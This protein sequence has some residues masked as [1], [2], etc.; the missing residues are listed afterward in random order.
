MRKFL[1]IVLLLIC[2]MLIFSNRLV[3]ANQSFSVTFYVDGQIYDQFDEIPAMTYLFEVVSEMNPTATGK[4]FNGWFL[5]ASYTQLISGANNNIEIDSNIAVY[6]YFETNGYTITFDSN[7]GTAVAA[8]TQDYGSSITAPANPTRTGYTFT[9]WSPGLPST[10]PS[11]D[12]T[13]TAQWSINSYYVYLNV[14]GGNYMAPVLYQYNNAVT[15]PSAPTKSGSTFLG[16]YFDPNYL[17]PFQAI[18]MPAGHLTLYARWQDPDVYYTVSFNSNGGSTISPQ[19]VLSGGT[20]THPPTAPIKQGHTFVA[21]YSDEGLTTEYGFTETVTGNLTLYAKYMIN[22]YTITFNT[23]GGTL[24]PSITQNYDTVIT[25]P[26]NPTRTGYTFTGWS[27]VIPARMPASNMTV[28]AQWQIIPVYFSV[29]FNSNGGSAVQSQSVLENSTASQPATP[30]RAGFTFL[31]WFSDV[32]LTTSFSFTTP[33]TENITL[34]AK[35][36]INSYNV[37]F[38]SNGG[39]AVQTQSITYN[40]TASLPTPPTKQGNIFVG[41]YQDV[42]LTVPFNFN[43]PITNHITLYAKWEADS[44]ALVILS[45]DSNGGSLVDP[46]TVVSGSTTQEPQPPIKANYI[47]VGW[48]SDQALT[49]AFNWNAPITANTTLYARW[50]ADTSVIWTVSFNSN[51]GSPVANRSVENGSSVNPPQAP[52][53]V[54]FMFDGWFTTIALS[55]PYTFSNPVTENITL[56]AKW[57]PISSGGGDPISEDPQTSEGSAGIYILL[58]VGVVII[59]SGLF[60]KK[61]RY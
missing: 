56:H 12:T 13:Q 44:A 61:R 28:T 59:L 55:T 50:T 20:A 53:R 6:G 34:Y 60:S 3:Y 18:N 24:V 25:Q 2:N 19:N 51:G 45:F 54:G 40:L 29:S 16:W 8:I 47:F 9:G 31:G 41:W 11:S 48:F 33:I 21:W 1:L 32:G 37:S 23:N 35:W 46:I 10:M 22:Q 49:Q 14:E 42:N 26:E 58:G 7:G 57:V 52:T 27:S 36:Q 15:E 30:T 4:T 5:T 43:T 17:D 39:S 38:N